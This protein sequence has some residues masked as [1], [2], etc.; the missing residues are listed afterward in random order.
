MKRLSIGLGILVL[1][2]VHAQKVSGHVPKLVVDMV[3][4]YKL[5][6]IK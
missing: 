3:L 1:C 5:L 6:K 2:H 4:N